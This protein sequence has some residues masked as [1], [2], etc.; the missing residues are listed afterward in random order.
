MSD[1]SLTK[2]RRHSIATRR[3]NSLDTENTFSLTAQS[4][5]ILLRHWRL[6]D[7]AEGEGAAAR[8]FDGSDS[9]DGW[10]DVDAPGDVYLALYAAGRIPD[11]F[12]D[13]GEK[14]C[15]WVKDREWWWRTDFEAPRAEDGQR[16]V[17]EF[18]GLDTLRNDLA[19]RRDCRQL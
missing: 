13:G 5:A 7:F 18:Q 4:V 8:A 15:A 16:I 3:V 9:D 17:L 10:I 6:M 1:Y 19:E 2:T 12:G 14:A 11:P